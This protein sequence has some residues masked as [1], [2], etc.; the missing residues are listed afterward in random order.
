MDEKGRPLDRWDENIVRNSLLLSGC[1]CLRV[2][3]VC[4]FDLKRLNTVCNN[5]CST[6]L[7]KMFI[8]ELY[9]LILCFIL[10]NGVVT[11][12]ESLVKSVYFCMFT[13]TKQ[14]FKIV[15]L[16]HS[17]MPLVLVFITLSLESHVYVS[18]KEMWV[19]Y[20]VYVCV[21]VCI[22]YIYIYIYIYI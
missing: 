10:W 5:T 1:W 6:F 7:W 18:C 14:N 4:Q 21:C 15:Q 16:P 19:K 13:Q 11:C 22:F 8:T 17:N 20:S 12:L 3:E 2:P 9:P